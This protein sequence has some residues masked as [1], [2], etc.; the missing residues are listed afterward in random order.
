MQNT[1]ILDLRLVLGIN[2]VDYEFL[3]VKMFDYADPKTNSLMGS[4]QLRTAGLNQVTGATDEIVLNFQC[5]EV[6]ANVI[7]VLN[8][9]FENGTRITLKTWGKKSREA[10]TADKSIIKTSP[11][12]GTIQEG[13]VKDLQLNIG[14][15][16]NMLNR[17]G[18]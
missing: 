2:D 5:Y 9:A 4:A 3:N 11:Y 1:T 7:T 6:S 12:N 14:V 8:D 15:V 16:R 18:L 10:M 17:G 13:D